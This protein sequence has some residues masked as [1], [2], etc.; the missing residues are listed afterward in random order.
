M[1]EV[2][3]YQR[4]ALLLKFADEQF[5]GLEIRMRRLPIGDLMAITTLA[6]LGDKIT[7]MADQ[8]A[9][10]M[11]SIQANML[12]WNLLDENKEPVPIVLGVP[13]HVDEET[14]EW[15]PST[16]M[17]AQDMELILSLVDTWVTQAAGISQSLGKASKNGGVHNTTPQKEFMLM[18][19][20][21]MAQVSS[22][23]PN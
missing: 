21:S 7:E 19:A 22:P 20:I 23:E 18:E 9:M 14:K 17:Y 11:K 3:G 1:D 13:A 15:I 16:G 5:E 4:G 10:L 2:Q 6:D 8:L 12:S